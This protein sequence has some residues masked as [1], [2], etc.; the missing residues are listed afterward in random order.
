[1]AAA[2]ALPVA[3]A[4]VPPSEQA[5]GARAPLYEQR[6]A[7]LTAVD[8]WSL[9]GR[10]AISDDA[11]GGSGQLRWRQRNGS[12]HMDFHGA[13]GRGAWRLEADAAGAELQLADGS[14]R[15]ADTVDALVRAEIGWRVPVEALAWWVRGLAA[16]GRLEHRQL[17]DQGRLSELRQSGWRIEF[18][19]Y[20]EIGPLSMPVRLT[21]RQ[22][23]RTVKLAIRKWELS[24]PDATP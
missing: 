8:D 18:D 4:T 12:S 17:D 13:L 21:A 9:E 23:D 7:Q 11:D 2:A 24:A 1:V 14:L 6:F 3:C 16:P 22:D 20:E 5:P 10:L 15:R 19:R